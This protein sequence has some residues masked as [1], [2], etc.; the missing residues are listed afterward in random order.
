M[1]EFD[2]LP[3]HRYRCAQCGY[4]AS[5]RTEPAQCPMCMRSEW[6]AEGWSPFA[7]LLGDL[8]PALAPMA[9]ELNE[10]AFQPGVPLS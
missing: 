1:A 6:L 7:A 3:L 4:G 2:P 9:R 8:D 5:C 10:T